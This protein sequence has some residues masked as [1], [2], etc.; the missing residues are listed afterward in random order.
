[1]I[2]IGRIQLIDLDMVGISYGS[3][4]HPKETS[5][6]KTLAATSSALKGFLAAW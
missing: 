3:H 2:E 6:R 4:P 5:R 1:V